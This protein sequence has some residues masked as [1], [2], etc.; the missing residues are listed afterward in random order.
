MRLSVTPQTVFINPRPSDAQQFRRTKSRTGSR[1]VGEDPSAQLQHLRRHLSSKQS[2]YTPSAPPS[3]ASSAPHTAP[4]SSPMPVIRPTPSHLHEVARSPSDSILSH[5]SPLSRLRSPISTAFQ[6]NVK[7]TPSVSAVDTNAV[8]H[9]ESTASMRDGDDEVE[10]Q[11]GRSTPV[12]RPSVVKQHSTVTGIIP[13]T[14][15]PVETVVGYDFGDPS[16]RALLESVYL[17]SFRDPLIE[18][19]PRISS[20]RRK[21]ALRSISSGPS[22]SAG[23]TSTPIVPETT[24]IS[25]LSGHSTPVAHILVSA[26]NLFFITASSDGHLQ[27]WDTSRLERS[28]TSKPRLKHHIGAELSSLC[29]LEGLHCFAVGGMDGTLTVI[30]VHVHV[31]SSAPKYRDLQIVRFLQLERQGDRIKAMSHFANG[32]SEAKRLHLLLLFSFPC[33]NETCITDLSNELICITE[34]SLIVVDLYSMLVTETIDFPLHLGSPVTLALGEQRIW[35]VVGTSSGWLTLWDLRFGVLLRS[36]KVD[37]A[38]APSHDPMGTMLCVRHP[39]QKTWVIVAGGSSSP[40]THL[41]SFNI[42]TGELME[43]YKVVSLSSPTSQPLES[44]LNAINVSS[45]STEEPPDP[46]KAIADLI[47]TFEV[48]RAES[49]HTTPGVTFAAVSEASPESSSEIE[50][51]VRISCVALTLAV[52]GFN[53]TEIFTGGHERMIRRL[54]LTEFSKSSF[55]ACTLGGADV[56]RRFVAFCNPAL[57]S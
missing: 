15:G 22:R 23:S 43:S 41:Q 11:S 18:F 54:D 9:L 32:K 1:A 47:S 30:R 33:P 48:S 21:S 16:I 42:E 4:Q 55:V 36:W 2:T 6:S 12:P 53:H 27:V 50:P 8:G 39:L 52:S 49:N 45:A 24:L 20:G 40:E 51:R 5:G 31:G 19:G 29:M 3:I 7:S 25:H 13:L 35:A 37:T 38:A 44:P 10:P 56:K 26:D 57:R 34:A 46:A 14:E 17:E 28:I